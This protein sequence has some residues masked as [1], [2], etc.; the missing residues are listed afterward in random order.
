MNFLDPI[1]VFFEKVLKYIF[2]LVAFALRRLRFVGTTIPI[3]DKITDFFEIFK[4]TRLF[5]LFN[6][7]ALLVFTVLPQGKDVILIVIEDLSNYQFWSL[8]TLVIS[9]ICWCIISEFGARYKIYVTDSSGFS[10]TDER[11]NFRKEAQRVVSSFYLLLP[12]VIVF[13]SII[14]VAFN[15]VKKWETH[16]IWP[17]A[18]VLLLLVLTFAFLSKYYLDDFYIA[19]ARKKGVWY[20]IRDEELNWANKLYGIYHDYVFMVR[21]ASNFKDGEIIKDIQGNEFK[22]APPNADIRNTYQRFTGLIEA[23]PVKAPNGPVNTIESFPRDFLKD[24]ELA[25]IEFSEVTFHADNYKPVLNPKHKDNKNEPEFINVEGKD[26]YYRWIYKC[27]PSF[28]KTLHK[29]IYIV[30]TGSLLML[31]LISINPFFS[32]YQFIGSP[33]L[34]CWSFACWLGIYTGLLYIDSR[35][36]RKIKI[37]VRWL[38]LIWF[39]IAS[40]INNDHPVR[41]SGDSGYTNSRLLLTE[42]FN[43]WTSRHLADAT[44]NHIIDTSFSKIKDTIRSKSDSIFYPV[45]FITAEGGALRTGAFT[46]ML[47][48]KL[49]DLFPHFKDHIYAFSSVSGGSVGISFF[50]AI[51]YLE[52]KDSTRPNSYY[53]TVTRKFFKQDQLSPTLAK[54]FYAEM[55]NCFLPNSLEKFDRT[56]ALEK[57]WEQSYANVFARTKDKNMYSTNFLSCYNSEINKGKILP[58]WFINTTEVESGLQCYIS[59][60]IANGFVAERQRDLLQEKIR[61]GINYS[62][63][64]N[65]SSRFPLF[66]PSAALYQSDDKTYHYVDGG[67]VENTGSKTMLE[68]LQCLHDTI[69]CKHIRPYVIQIKF[70]DSDSSKFR[71][72]GFLNEISS[73]LNGIVNTRG[74]TSITYSELLQREVHS[75]G[76]KVIN[77]PLS[78]SGKEVPMSW[79]FSQ[80]SFSNLDSAVSNLLTNSTNEL[81][82]LP[83][84]CKK[85][86]K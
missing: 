37:S 10:L 76:G 46:A 48:A 11:V 85:N 59:N 30:A 14:T 5:F 72:T 35:Y 34:V 86:N 53:Q 27:N 54:F 36:K 63:A 25:P 71:G 51:A 47:L 17:F 28:Y 83:L 4:T 75:L 6:L 67:Y 69:S 45:Y 18:V 62:T 24:G 49:Q 68:I 77:V 29:Q 84:F 22:D 70:S 12:I 73:I 52:P 57:S 60:V 15:N 33:A 82:K 50:N 21:K 74:G 39:F 65:F 23:L 16:D 61:Y 20:K 32:I 55:L 9:L 40:F 8:V 43:Q 58:A 26:G 7:L 81:H 80:R 31:L 64:V 44:S 56:I 38:L 42:H 2:N 79:V 78:A 3:E 13:I 66:S 41:N 1:K 19:K